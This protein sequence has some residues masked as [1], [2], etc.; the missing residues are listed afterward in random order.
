MITH[1]HSYLT[2]NFLLHDPQKAAFNLQVKAGLNQKIFARKCSLQ[3]IDKNICKEFL[4]NHHLITLNA[5]HFNYGLLYEGEL[6][7]VAGFSKGRKMNRLPAHLRSYELIFFCCK[8][9]VTVT[10]GL[11]K[12][13]KHFVKEKNNVGDIM[14]YI[15]KEIGTGVGFK[16]IGFKL[17][18]ETKPL[19]FLINLT[20]G[21][22]TPYD[23]DKK[24]DTTHFIKI[25]N[26]GNL[27]LVLNVTEVRPDE[28]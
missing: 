27:K 24:V 3:K 9:G 11:S 6:I 18:S 19:A 22:R 28:T 5:A 20:T 7:A 25:K 12:F 1:P 15:D 13:I 26:K 2:K 8:G 21:E 16:K 17:H 10:G 4:N 23:P 14:T